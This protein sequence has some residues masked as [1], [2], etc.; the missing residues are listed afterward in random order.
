MAELLIRSVD[1]GTDPEHWRDGDVVFVAPD[2]HVW[3]RMESY[4]VWVA[5]G[6]D[7]AAWPGGFAIVRL[8]SMSLAAAEDLLDEGKGNDGRE[9]RRLRKLDYAALERRDPG[10][11]NPDGTRR[12]TLFAYGYLTRADVHTLA[13]VANAK[14]GISKLVRES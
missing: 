5:E 14:T 7:P 6:R 4:E 3:G 1:N 13:N 2:G 11:T 10:G 12:D 8:P 9:Y